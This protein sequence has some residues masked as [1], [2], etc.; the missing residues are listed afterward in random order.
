ML[1]LDDL[2]KKLDQREVV[3][4]SATEEVRNL[5]KQADQLSNENTKLNNMVSGCSFW[6]PAVLIN[7]SFNYECGYYIK[8]N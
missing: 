2:K 4:T 6:S 8:P 7:L 3:A 1:Q 5:R